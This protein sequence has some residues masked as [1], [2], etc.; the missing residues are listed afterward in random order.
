MFVSFWKLP[1]T[2]PNILKTGLISGVWEGQIVKGSKVL[3]LMYSRLLFKNK[4]LYFRCA[5]VHCHI[6]FKPRDFHAFPPCLWLFPSPLQ[7]NHG[8][9][10]ELYQSLLTQVASEHFYFWLNSLKE[11]SHAEQCLTGLQDDDCSSALSC[12]AESL[13]SYHRGIASLTV[14]VNCS[15]IYLGDLQIKRAAC[16]S[17]CLTRLFRDLREM[18]CSFRQLYVQQRFT[19]T[20]QDFRSPTACPELSVWILKN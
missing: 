12:I 5:G 20:I 4:K 9:A 19:L 6:V 17:C 11:F 2:G 16:F 3:S 15:F 8:M 7:G 1:V 18:N 13:K 10:R 14:S